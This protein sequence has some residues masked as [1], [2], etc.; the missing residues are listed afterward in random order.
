MITKY[1]FIED[2][3]DHTVRTNQK[4]WRPLE[5]VKS[6]T[7]L[8]LFSKEDAEEFIADWIKDLRESVKQFQEAFT[9]GRL[10]SIEAYKRV[11][12][13]EGWSGL[14]KTEEDIKESFLDDVKDYT[15]CLNDDLEMLKQLEN[16]VF[17]VREI[18]IKI[19]E[20]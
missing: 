8:Y 17:V 3:F 20:R 1:Y 7:G 19:I 12:E 4:T 11:A 6:I 5:K 14:F 13:E 2:T 9:T 16:N 18:E 15:E 10:S